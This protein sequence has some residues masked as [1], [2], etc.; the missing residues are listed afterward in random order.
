MLANESC[1]L[2]DPNFSKI[3]AVAQNPGN[4]GDSRA[5]CTNTPG[6]PQFIQKWV[7]KPLMPVVRLFVD[8]TFRPSIEAGV[9]MVELAV[10]QI[11]DGKR[12]YFTLLEKGDLDSTVLD[13]EM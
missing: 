10:N 12:G 4:M 6:S 11:Y 3:T 8:P 13:E 1:L 7:M 2:Q 9:D 5:F